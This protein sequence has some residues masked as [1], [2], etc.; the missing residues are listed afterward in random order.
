MQSDKEVNHPISE[1]LK[2]TGY[3]VEEEYFYRIN[4]E[5]IE[6]NRRH[7]DEQRRMQEAQERKNAHWMMCPKCGTQ[8][9]ESDFYSVKAEICESCSGVFLDK[10]ELE[11]IL[12]AHGPKAV[13]ALLKKWLAE[14]TKP[15]KSGLHHFPV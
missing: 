11:H 15:Q 7:L 8:L 4:A 14:A 2:K 3:G 5:L 13:T 12:S 10:G 9:K 1:T 6:R